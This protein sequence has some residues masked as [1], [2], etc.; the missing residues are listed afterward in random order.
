MSDKHEEAGTSPSFDVPVS[1]DWMLQATVLF[2]GRC[3]IFS[4]RF[5]GSGL[6]GG[7]HAARRVAQV[8]GAMD[9]RLEN[10][11][12]R[13]SAGTLDLPQSIRILGFIG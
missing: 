2:H 11:W 10:A 12:M 8:P 9:S 3:G 13:G 1:T 7:L 6:Q 4:L 5:R